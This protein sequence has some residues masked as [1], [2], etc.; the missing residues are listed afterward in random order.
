MDG[1]LRALD[2]WM[3]KMEEEDG[4]RAMQLEIEDEILN[5]KPGSRLAEGYGDE[6]EETQEKIE[7]HRGQ[8]EKGPCI[9]IEPGDWEWDIVFGPIDD[10]R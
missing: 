3:T 9:E 8:G 5:A 7:K 4:Y 1:N 6:L 10:G 2:R